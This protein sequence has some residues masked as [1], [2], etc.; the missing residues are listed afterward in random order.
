MV[1]ASSIALTIDSPQEGM[2]VDGG[3][4]L[5]VRVSASG[6]VTSV[7]LLGDRILLEKSAPPFEFTVNLPDDALGH[8]TFVAAAKAA[9]GTVAI[10]APVGI[11]VR[12][13]T[14]IESLQLVATSRTL[15]LP[16]SEPMH[17]SAVF[18]DGVLRDVTDPAQGTT[19][20]SG[21]ESIVT[22]S[23][24]GVLTARGAGKTVVTVRN[25]AAE[26]ATFVLVVPASPARRRPVRIGP[27]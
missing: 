2:I 3:I 12:R 20:T 11:E 10:S 23:P 19:Y 22:V 16:G 27:E 5:T 13:N 21:D 24:E 4:P 26:A 14:P 1:N 9:D 15:L 25:G 6:P 7:T 8:E 17:V 18:S